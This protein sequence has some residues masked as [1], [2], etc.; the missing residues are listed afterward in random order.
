MTESNHLR[1]T[2]SSKTELPGRLQYASRSTR[3]RPPRFW[4]ALGFAL[5][6]TCLLSWLFRI[7]KTIEFWYLQRQCL[8]H[9]LPVDW[10]VYEEDEHAGNL[11]L[12]ADRHYKRTSVPV[13]F[14]LPQSPTLNPIVYVFPPLEH[15][16]YSPEEG[17]VFVHGLAS[18]DCT[19]LVAVRLWVNGYPDGRRDLMFSVASVEPKPLWGSP[20]LGD[21]VWIDRVSLPLVA[22]ERCRVFAGQ[23]AHGNP[24]SFSITCEVDGQKIILGGS[25]GEDG[26]VSFLRAS[27]RLERLEW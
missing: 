2:R 1:S 26:R 7:D 23:V 20:G 9:S 24:S 21:F 6:G 4:I 3:R 15:L 17:V 19:R 27:T 14:K 5:A 8:V 18:G 16:D 12:A 13:R 22:N 11:L 10:V 25:L